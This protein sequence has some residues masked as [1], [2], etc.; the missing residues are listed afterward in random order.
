[1][2]QALAEIVG[3]VAAPLPAVAA[4]AAVAPSTTITTAST[5]AAAARRAR[6]TWPGFIHGQS[7]AV[8]RFAVNLS[9]GVLS[10]LL[11]AHCHKRKSAGFACEFVLHERHFLHCAGLGEKLLQLVFGRVEGKISYV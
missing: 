7:S 3:L 8:Y 5:A 11:G 2:T 4:P 9:D 6:L 1:L 10:F